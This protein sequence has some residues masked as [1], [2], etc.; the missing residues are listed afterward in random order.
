MAL[1]QGRQDGTEDFNLGLKQ[2]TC[3]YHQLLP[4]PGSAIVDAF[5]EIISKELALF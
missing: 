5:S 3:L 2:C 4:L 1:S